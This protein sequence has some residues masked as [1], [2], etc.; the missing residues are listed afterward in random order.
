MTQKYRSGI[1]IAA[2][3]LLLVTAT[4]SLWWFARPGGR[5]RST[6]NYQANRP[7]ASSPPD[8]TSTRSPRSRPKDLTGDL[9]RILGETDPGKRSG[10]FGRLLKQWFRDDPEAALAYLRTVPRGAEY[11]N[12]I[13]IVLGG[14]AETDPERALK[15]AADMASKPEEWIVY[16]ALIAAIAAKD[17]NLAHALLDHIPAGDP[18]TNALRALFSQW[19]YQS[20]EAA[21]AAA[22]ASPDPTERAI[23]VESTLA[24]LTRNDPAKAATL[25]AQLLTGIQ[26]DR[27]I[28]NCIR[29]IEEDDPLAAKSMLDLLPAGESKSEATLRLIRSLAAQDTPAA[30]AWVE[31]MAGSP[32][33]GIALRNLLDVWSLTAPDDASAHVAAMPPGPAQNT[34]AAHLASLLATTNP[35]SAITWAETLAS[36]SAKNAA[37][38][39]IASAWA[40]KDPAAATRWAAGFPPDSPLRTETLRGTLSFW[41][42]ANPAGAADF[43]LTL[44]ANEQPAALL[45][46][47]PTWTQ[48][49]PADALAWAK[50]LP[51][52]DIREIALDSV[53][54]RWADNHPADAARWILTEPETPARVDHVRTITRGWLATNSTTALAWIKNIPYGPTRDGAADVAAETLATSNPS[55]ARTFANSIASQPLREARLEQV[56]N[57]HPLAH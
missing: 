11:T 19:A 14:I 36:A 18:R 40:R 38:A 32:L 17:I 41:A 49:R 53:V 26:R 6:G 34:A 4:L 50:S 29:Q 44:P 37:L 48:A 54:T 15:L 21:L 12:G 20:P 16:N 35:T 30:L 9:N 5:S 22:T 33:Q 28:A 27:V 2:V 10:D 51:D 52:P 3:A 57:A 45:K 43:L 46:V 1:L 24:I 13:L 7:A 25:A 56:A 47:L 42:L 39:G 8:S 55:L 23:A 31:S